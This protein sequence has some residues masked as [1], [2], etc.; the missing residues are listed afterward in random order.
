MPV[1]SLFLPRSSLICRRPKIFRAF[2]T[3]SCS[4]RRC[5]KALPVI[6][7]SGLNAGAVLSLYAA[8]RIVEYR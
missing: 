6:R 3:I 4:S 5:P 2:G 7:A 1:N 8:G